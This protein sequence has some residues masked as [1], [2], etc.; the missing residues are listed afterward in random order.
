VWPPVLGRRGTTPGIE[1]SAAAAQIDFLPQISGVGCAR[2]RSI[3]SQ[4]R[5]T[6]AATGTLAEARRS[7]RRRGGPCAVAGRILGRPRGGPSGGGA[8]GP[9][10][11]ARRLL[12]RPDA[13]RA[14]GR[15]RGGPSVGGARFRQ[16]VA[17]GE[18]GGYVGAG[19]SGSARGRR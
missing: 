10:S 13:R 1:E 8:E 5:R 14:V 18:G 4:R 12:G 15:R 3:R 19:W 9:R 7:T 17:R 11:A 6:E 2:M 16:A